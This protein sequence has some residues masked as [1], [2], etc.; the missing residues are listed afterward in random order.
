M[1]LGEYDFTVV[2]ELLPDQLFHPDFFFDPER[3]GFEEGLNARWDAR[4][5]G[6]EDAVE[7]DEGFFVKGDKFN[8]IDLDASFPQTIL[9]GEFWKRGIVLLAGEAF[10]LRGSY[11]CSVPNQTCGAVMIKGGNPQNSFG[12]RQGAAFRPLET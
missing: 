5:V 6:M 11:N 12:H 4:Q 3:N 1:V 2:T 10:L 9:D 8:V 7:F